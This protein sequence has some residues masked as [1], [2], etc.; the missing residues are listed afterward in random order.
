MEFKIVGLLGLIFIA[1]ACSSAGSKGYP[2]TSKSDFAYELH[3]TRIADPYQW[4]EDG[5]DPKVRTWTYDQEKLT[6]S[7]LDPLPQRR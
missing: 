1:S 5:K 2:L 7:Y 4:L 3:G 6:R